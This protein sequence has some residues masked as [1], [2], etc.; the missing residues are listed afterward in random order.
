MAIQLKFAITIERKWMFAWSNKRQQQSTFSIPQRPVEQQ[1]RTLFTAHK[2]S[3]SALVLCLF[4]QIININFTI[5][6]IFFLLYFFIFTSTG[7]FWRNFHPTRTG[8]TETTGTARVQA[9]ST[10]ASLEQYQHPGREN[11]LHSQPALWRCWP[12][13]L[14]LG[15]QRFR[16]KHY[17]HEGT[18]RAWIVG[19]AA[20]LSGR[21]YR[22]SAA[23]KSYRVR[24]RL[25]GGLVCGV[26]AQLWA[27]LHPEGSGCSASTRTN[28]DSGRLHYRSDAKTQ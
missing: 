3:F 18:E 20:W 1:T 24:Y 13:C 12:R 28:E 11:V 17:G 4:H 15:R 14:L 10:R 27:R 6:M 21:R 19:P 23:G 16:A 25:A 8:R 2:C 9:S 7:R 26:S 5:F 22:N